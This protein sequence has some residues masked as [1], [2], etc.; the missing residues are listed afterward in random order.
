[1]SVTAI[2]FFLVSLAPLGFA[3][4]RIL[5]AG[6]CRSWI[7][8]DGEIFKAWVEPVS[9]GDGYRVEIRY[10]YEVN[11]KRYE[12]CQT[13]LGLLSTPYLN[14]KHFQ[15]EFSAK[16]YLAEVLATP[17]VQV[18]LD[19]TNPSQ[20]L[21]DKSFPILFISVLCL[22]SVALIAIGVFFF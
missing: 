3:A 15:S 16:C 22:S 14:R 11:G 6:R 8:V 5:L 4:K 12:S 7:V 2:I 17:K 13:D 19:P 20:A 21:L 10:A 1:M 18:W 9:T